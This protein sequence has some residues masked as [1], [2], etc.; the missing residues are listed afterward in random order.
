MLHC[1]NIKWKTESK[2]EYG[3]KC[4]CEGTSAH[5]L[6][7]FYFFFFKFQYGACPACVGM[8]CLSVVNHTT[9]NIVTY[10]SLRVNM[11]QFS[12]RRYEAKNMCVPQTANQHESLQNHFLNSYEPEKQ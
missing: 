11:N 10:L 12:V 4:D 2:R 1:V 9:A 7:F 8:L 5:F 6:F 3:I